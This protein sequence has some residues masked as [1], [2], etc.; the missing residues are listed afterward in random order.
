MSPA[1]HLAHTRAQS[2]TPTPSIKQ[3]LARRGRVLVATPPQQSRM[4]DLNVKGVI[5]HSPSSTF[6][7]LPLGHLPFGTSHNAH[8]THYKSDIKHNNREDSTFEDNGLDDV[9]TQSSTP[10]DA[11]YYTA[12]PKR[13]VFNFEQHRTGRLY[14]PEHGPGTHGDA[15]RSYTRKMKLRP[16]TAPEMQQRRGNIF[17]H[18]SSHEPPANDVRIQREHKDDRVW[19]DDAASVAVQVFMSRRHPY[20]A[21]TAQEMADERSLRSLIVQFLVSRLDAKNALAIWDLADRTQS[22]EL[23]EAAF[24]YTQRNLQVI[25]SASEGFWDL[26]FSHVLKLVT[27]DNLMLFNEAQACELL[28]QWAHVDDLRRAQ[29]EVMRFKERVAELESLRGDVYPLLQ[30][31]LETERLCEDDKEQHLRRRRDA[32][33]ALTAE[34]EAARARR[35]HALDKCVAAQQRL[36]R[37]SKGLPKAREMKLRFFNMQ[38]PECVRRVMCAVGVLLRIP[39]ELVGPVSTHHGASGPP[40]ARSSPLKYAGAYFRGNGVGDGADGKSIGSRGDARDASLDSSTGDAQQ[41]SVDGFVEGDS[42]GHDHGVSILSPRSSGA[43]PDE[44][45]L[46]PLTPRGEGSASVVTQQLSMTQALQLYNDPSLPV[47]LR[48]VMIQ[49]Q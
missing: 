38:P 8:A 28:C 26:P 5:H 6:S 31:R 3:Q 15:Y 22:K 29:L 35:T 20:A 12:V 41:V 23:A 45:D 13:P 43:D 47:W 33:I 32:Y 37:V 21:T 17:A 30:L 9:H 18:S 10:S 16:G 49:Q 48:Q 4:H 19:P 2:D 46:L 44:G 14:Y 25:V 7:Y 40:S 42:V 36:G 34:L 11:L 27:S 39:G 1:S 24:E